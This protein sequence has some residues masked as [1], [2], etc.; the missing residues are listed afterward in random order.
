MY[1]SPCKRGISDI[2]DCIQS[3][4]FLIPQSAGPGRADSLVRTINR[5]R[6][7]IMLWLTAACLAVHSAHLS[8]TTSGHESRESPRVATDC[9]TVSVFH[10]GAF[11]VTVDDSCT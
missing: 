2:A 6:D 11:N 3:Q 8:T 10:Y 1:A 5:H 7:A 4:Q 9:V